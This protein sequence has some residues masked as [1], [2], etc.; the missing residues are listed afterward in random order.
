MAHLKSSF[1][2]RLKTLP[3]PSSPFPVPIHPID[4][5]FSVY[6]PTQ[7]PLK[8]CVSSR[9]ITR[10]LRY[11]QL[12]IEIVTS[13]KK[14]MT[15]SFTTVGFNFLQNCF[16]WGNWKKDSFNNVSNK[17]KCFLHADIKYLC[18]LPKITESLFHCNWTPQKSKTGNL[19]VC[20]HILV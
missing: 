6:K 5:S 12:H 9:R 13:F 16:E 19:Y 17:I 7:N 10:I 1:L 8:I 20:W 2:L 4:T 3:T 11:T 18:H 14:W 15:S